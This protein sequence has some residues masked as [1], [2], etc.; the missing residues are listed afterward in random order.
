MVKISANKIFFKLFFDNVNNFNILMRLL[1]VG[2]VNDLLIIFEL[3]KNILLGNIQLIPKDL[4]K[5]RIYEKKLIFLSENN[6]SFNK[7]VKLLKKN[8]DM[9]QILVLIGGNCILKNE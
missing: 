6:K 1:S 7:K 3:C 4:N 8:I 5:L 2:K 9:F